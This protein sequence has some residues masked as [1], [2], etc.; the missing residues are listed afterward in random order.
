MKIRAIGV[1]ACL[2]ESSGEG[3]FVP[4][5][6]TVMPVILA[7]SQIPPA[8]PEAWQLISAAI[9]GVTVVG[10]SI[11]SDETT[12]SQ[13]IQSAG[14]LMQFIV[15]IVQQKGLP[16][17]SPSISSSQL[18]PALQPFWEHPTSIYPSRLTCFAEEGNCSAR[19][20]SDGK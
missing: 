8:G 2:A 9:K 7:C 18:A 19:H 3:V 16:L 17:I 6:A 10:Q 13:Y 11:A 20:F 15:P 1:I 14:Q 4:F 12:E 5:Y